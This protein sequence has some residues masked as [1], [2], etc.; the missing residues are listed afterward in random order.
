M[1]DI[2]ELYSVNM[3]FAHINGR[4]F[5]KYEVDFLVKKPLIKRSKD[6]TGWMVDLYLGYSPS[7]LI[8][9]AF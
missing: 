4:L 7:D 8:K 5:P 6:E 1:I 2:T 3:C 9:K